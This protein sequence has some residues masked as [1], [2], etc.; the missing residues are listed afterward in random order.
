MRELGYLWGAY[1]DYTDFF[2]LNEN[3]PYFVGK[4]HPLVQIEGEGIGLFNPR[5][6]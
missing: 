3:T 1:A 4:V 5:Y 6:Q 2:P